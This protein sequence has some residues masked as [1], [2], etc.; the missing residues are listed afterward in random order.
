MK[1]H[2]MMVVVTGMLVLSAGLQIAE[3]AGRGRGRQVVQP[4]EAL[5]A[6]EIDGLLYM[7]EEE[8]LAH[9][10]YVT[11]HA[12]WGTPVFA[13]IAVSEQRHTDRILGLLNRYGIPDPVQEFGVFSNPDLQ[14]LYDA[15]VAQGS[16]SELSALQ[17]GALIEEVDM[18]DIVEKMAATERADI[19]NVYGKLLSGSE[20]HLRAFVGL[21]EANSGEAYVAQHLSQEEVDQILGR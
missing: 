3:A 14:S 15:L 9:D 12:L 8:K 4:V 18:V 11:F 2:S 19:L 21:I 13:S 17:V 7:R 5:S 1:Y 20:N 6:A 16:A 10:V